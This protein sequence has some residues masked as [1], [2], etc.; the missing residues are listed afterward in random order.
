MQL[1]LA[2][3]HVFAAVVA[4]LDS[5]FLEPG[6]VAKGIARPDIADSASGEYERMTQAPM[7]WLNLRKTKLSLPPARAVDHG[8]GAA[9][10]KHAVSSGWDA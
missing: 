4:S 8:T 3:A 6:A 7:V 10:V 2:F 9:A 5:R 1:K